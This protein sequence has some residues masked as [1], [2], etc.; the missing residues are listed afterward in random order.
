MPENTDGDKFQQEA[1]M[2]F[3]FFQLRMKRNT[4]ID[5]LFEYV[6]VKVLC[7]SRRYSRHDEVGLN[8][9]TQHML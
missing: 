9:E 6:E 3:F 4:V 8:N 2:A 1:Q 5:L 7:A